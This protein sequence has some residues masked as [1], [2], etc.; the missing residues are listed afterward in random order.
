[1]TRRTLRAWLALWTVLMVSAIY[2]AGWVF[3]ATIHQNTRVVQLAP[4][5]GVTTD[6]G[7]TIRLLS[8]TRATEVPAKYD[9]VATPDPG[10][11]FVIVRFEATITTEREI[12]PLRLVGR[13][14]RTWEMTNQTIL[15][16]PDAFCMSYPLNTPT[17]GEI[18]YEI[19]ASEA[20]HLLGVYHEYLRDWRRQAYAM[21]PPVP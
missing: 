9:N 5:E 12:C 11:V 4:G 7:S 16:E 19:P 10:A 1:M 20:D 2:V 17:L 15:R 14:G 8:M 18:I 21:R 3:Y 6:N 13:Y